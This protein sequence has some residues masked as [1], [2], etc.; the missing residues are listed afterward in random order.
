MAMKNENW[1]PIKD[2]EGF[3]E[4]SDHGRVRSLARVIIRS[5]GCAQSIRACIRKTPLN[6]VSRYS[7]VAAAFIGPRPPGKEVAHRDGDPTNARLENLRYATPKENDADKIMHGTR[8]RG[9]RN[10]RAKFT[11]EQI[12]EIRRARLSG[13]KYATIAERYNVAEATPRKIASRKRWNHVI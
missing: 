5:N 12:R 9:M 3:Y 7:L 8:P 11:D 1:L 2:Y 10:G 13:E 4:I 6:K